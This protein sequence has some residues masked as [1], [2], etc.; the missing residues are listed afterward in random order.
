MLRRT[1]RRE[2]LRTSA[3]SS[4]VRS[5]VTGRPA[6]RR[7]RS[8]VREVIFWLSLHCWFYGD[9]NVPIAIEMAH[10]DNEP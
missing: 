3:T 6:G 2:T 4:I 8:E 1:V 10:A 7:R 5:L 9:D